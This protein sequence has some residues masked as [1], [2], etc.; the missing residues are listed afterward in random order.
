VPHKFE[1]HP[2]HPAVA[3]LVRPHADLG[4][5]IQANKDEAVKLAAD[6][7]AVEAVIK[8]FNP[9]FNCRA[10]AARRKQA[11][12]P[13]FKRGTLF[14]AAWTCSAPRLSR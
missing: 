12:N 3:Y 2:D 5:R 8:L 11:T 13:W 10:I 1:A 7:Q 9:E 6:M 14:R 4:G